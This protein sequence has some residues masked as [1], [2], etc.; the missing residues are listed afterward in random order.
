MRAPPAP[1][2]ILEWNARAQEDGVVV[3]RMM[4][5]RNLVADPDS[6]SNAVMNGKAS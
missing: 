1:R 5:Y 6:E 4:R 2:R 3:R